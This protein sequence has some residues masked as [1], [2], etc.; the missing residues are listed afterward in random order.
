MK[1][2][3]VVVFFIIATVSLAQNIVIGVPKPD[4]KIHAGSQFNVRI[5]KPD[6]LT[7]SLQIALVIAVASCANSYCLTPRDGLGTVLYNG[8]FNPQ[9]RTGSSLPPYQDFDV[10]MPSYFPTGATQLNVANFELIGAELYPSLQLL[11]S[12]LAVIH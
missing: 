2:L 6:T 8:T 11:N 5:E 3:S 7:N 1:S 12:S 4:T 9:F 10:T